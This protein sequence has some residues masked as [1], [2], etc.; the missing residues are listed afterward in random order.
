METHHCYSFGGTCIKSP[1]STKPRPV[2]LEVIASERSVP[3]LRS[4][5]L[6]RHRHTNLFSDILDQ[7]VGELSVAD[8]AAGD[9]H[10]IV[11][12]SDG[13]VHT[14]GNNDRGQLGLSDTT[15][16]TVN[17]YGQ[18]SL[19]VDSPFFVEQLLPVESLSRSFVTQVSAGAKHSLVLSEDGKVF[20]AGDNSFGQLGLPVFSPNQF[21]RINIIDTADPL[22]DVGT[23]VTMGYE[24]REEGGAGPGGTGAPLNAVGISAGADFSIMVGQPQ[25]FVVW[26]TEEVEEWLPLVTLSPTTSPTL[27][28]TITIMTRSPTAVM[29][30][31]PSPTRMPT[32]SPTFSPTYS[33][34]MSPTSAPTIA[35]TKSPTSSPTENATDLLEP[36]S[37]EEELFLN[38][39]NVTES[40][41]LPPTFADGFNTTHYRIVYNNTYNVSGLATPVWAVG[42]HFGALYTSASSNVPKRVQGIGQLSIKQVSS[43]N[44]HVLMLTTD[45]KVYAWG[46]NYEGQLGLGENIT[47][48]TSPQEVTSLSENIVIEVAAGDYHSFVITDEGHLYCW[49]KNADNQCGFT[50]STRVFLPHLVPRGGMKRNGLPRSIGAGPHSSFVVDYQGNVYAWGWNV[51]GVMG[52]P[53]Q[54]Y[55][56]AALLEELEHPMMQQI[57][58]GSRI[59]VASTVA[60]STSCKSDCM[61]HGACYYD[62][63][64]TCGDLWEGDDCSTPICLKAHGIPCGGNGTCNFPESVDQDEPWCYCNEGF[65]G[66]YL[67]ENT[68]YFS[69]EVVTLP[70]GFVV[71]LFSNESPVH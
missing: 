33:P 59:V 52:L 56:E 34:T 44:D 55:S 43:G 58:Q 51:D 47:H 40:P 25:P 46:R 42:K 63:T 69:F 7:W 41:T 13:S 2:L 71:D 49:G 24:S 3:G 31:T 6:S 16:A 38:V 14:M 8:L 28:P 70:F 15:L 23:G 29:D 10:I 64:C 45:G 21:E 65:A 35:P 37:S 26:E 9:D 1:A 39:S 53:D 27:T 36:A 54:F 32:A 18:N 68:G 12:L 60:S 30:V 67:Y 19:N 20:A 17:G 62:S 61:Y 4:V 57:A 66:K 48:A 50:G 5:F 11:L 22:A